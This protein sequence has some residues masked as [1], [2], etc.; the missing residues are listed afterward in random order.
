MR[1]ATNQAV[2]RGVIDC[3]NLNVAVVVDV[4]VV[5]VV[6]VAPQTTKRGGEWKQCTHGQGQQTY[7]HTRVVVCI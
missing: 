2:A 7:K 5:V 3:G 6:D 4:V 1:S